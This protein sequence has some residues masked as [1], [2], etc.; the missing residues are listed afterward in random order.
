[1]TSTVFFDYLL[2][3]SIPPTF[4][5]K[6]CQVSFCSNVLVCSGKCGACSFLWGSCF[7]FVTWS[8][9]ELCFQL[10]LYLHHSLRCSAT[11]FLL[12]IHLIFE[13]IY[14]NKGSLREYVSKVTRCSLQDEVNDCVS[15]FLPLRLSTITRGA[16]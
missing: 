1:M 10:S 13:K 14:D 4:R 3:V 8:A 12:N 6:F 16:Y 11:G 2:D 7:L 5:S 9:P 15:L